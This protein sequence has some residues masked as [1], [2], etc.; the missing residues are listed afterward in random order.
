M[1]ILVQWIAIMVFLFGTPCAMVL[2]GY[3]GI[4]PSSIWQLAW[5]SMIGGLVLAILDT[6]TEYKQ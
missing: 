6:C 1:K 2:Y 5:P 4:A 3:W